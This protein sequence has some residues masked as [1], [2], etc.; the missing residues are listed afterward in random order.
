MPL[1]GILL[2]ALEDEEAHDELEP[3][4]EKLVEEGRRAWPGLPLEPEDFVKHLA[5]QQRKEPL[6]EWLRATHAADLYLACA[7][8]ARLPGAL[9]AFEAQLVPKL[10]GYLAA[11]RVSP[12]TSEDVLQALREKLFVSGRIGAYTGRG[13]LINWLRVITLRTT[14]DLARSQGESLADSTLGSS[15]RAVEG[16]DPE[17]DYIK[18]HYREIFRQALKDAVLELDPELRTIL[19][20]HYVDGITLEKVSA[21]LGIGRSTVVRRIS[22]AREAILAGARHLSCAR[23]DIDPA[24]V[25][26]L[27]QLLRSRLDVSLT[28][29]LRSTST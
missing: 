6:L 23:A 8:A 29:L 4:L 16:D 2:A 9:E 1:G 15:R 22:E 11:S 3:L 10:A 5:S 26:S 21:A 12:T 25:E 14:V 7:C 19:R 24:E 13:S 17:L 28:R 27:L 20:L 18:E